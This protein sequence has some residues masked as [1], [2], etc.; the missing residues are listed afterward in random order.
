MILLTILR[1]KKLMAVA[2]VAVMAAVGVFAI[3]SNSNAPDAQANGVTGP[4]FDFVNMVYSTDH[5]IEE[6]PDHNDACASDRRYRI[7]VS[8]GWDTSGLKTVDRHYFDIG[9]DPWPHSLTISPLNAGQERYQF[10]ITATCKDVES[11][12]LHKV[13]TN[14]EIRS[15]GDILFVPYSIYEKDADTIYVHIRNSEHCDEG[16]NFRKWI[17][18]QWYEEHLHEGAWEQSYLDDHM[19]M[20]TVDKD[21]E[22]TYAGLDCAWNN[23]GTDAEPDY[24]LVQ[25]DNRHIIRQRG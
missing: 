14:P 17:N 22:Y 2:L 24:E 1:S 18:R 11:N 9:D 21:R 12:K 8:T 4:T 25:M 23:A 13:Q 19:I 10:R 7:R 3:T 15:D 20:Y 6:L 5:L 16:F